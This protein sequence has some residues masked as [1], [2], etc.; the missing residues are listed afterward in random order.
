MVITV[1]GTGAAA[2]LLV[3]AAAV[4]H[5]QGGVIR[6]LVLYDGLSSPCPVS[7]H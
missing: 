1:S 6:Y 7:G 3:T 5:L 4:P 2:F